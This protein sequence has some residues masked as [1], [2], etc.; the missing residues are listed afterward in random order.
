MVEGHAG[1]QGAAGLELPG[2]SGG[3]EDVGAGLAR[4]LDGG[5]PDAA[6]PGVDEHPLLRRAAAYPEERLPGREE[7]LRN[8]RRFLERQARRDPHREHAREERPLGVAPA[9]KEPCDPVSAAPGT[10]RRA[11][12]LDHPG[13]LEP[14]DRAGA[15]RRRIPALPLQDVRAVHARRPHPHDEVALRRPRV[16]DLVEHELLGATGTGDDDR[17]HAVRREA[18]PPVP[19]G[20]TTRSVSGS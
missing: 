6:R 4:E 11:G 20:E 1:A 8:R 12:V 2:R 9:R 15:R 14:R 19:D 7:D 18:P 16:R 3:D 5:R 10:R 13:D 17:L